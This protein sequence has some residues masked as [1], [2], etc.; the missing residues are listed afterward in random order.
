MCP[1]SSIL[2][3]V[4][5][6]YVWDTGGKTKQWNGH[7]EREGGNLKRKK[8][9]E[10]R[11]NHNRN[12]KATAEKQSESRTR[13]TKVIYLKSIMFMN[14]VRATGH[15]GHSG[16]CQ[17]PG[18]K[19]FFALFFLSLYSLAIRSSEFWLTR[20]WCC[21]LSFNLM[22]SAIHVRS[23]QWPTVYVCV[24]VC[25]LKFWWHFFGCCFTRIRSSE[26]V[27]HVCFSFE[28]RVAGDRRERENCGNMHMRGIPIGLGNCVYA[29]GLSCANKMNLRLTID[30]KKRKEKKKRK[31]KLKRNEECTSTYNYIWINVGIYI[32]NSRYLVG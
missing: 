31:K 30:W 9:V 15:I 28:L 18:T 29:A 10:Q 24:C 27:R 3:R 5:V 19:A 7:D 6:R 26:C 32:C 20:M 11:E 12:R 17:A 8:K 22:W 4:A 14:F 1:F 2:E 21:A 23:R 13:K 16:H 25:E